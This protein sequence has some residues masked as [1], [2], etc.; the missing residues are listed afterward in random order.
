[1]ASSRKIAF[2][3]WIK[4]A[5]SMASWE[6]IKKECNRF[7]LVDDDNFVF[8]QYTGL[9]DKNGVEICEGDIVKLNP[10]DDD[11][12]D[13]VVW[14]ESKARF[15][16]KS[17]VDCPVK[18]TMTELARDSTMIKLADWVYGSHNPMLITGSIYENPELL[19]SMEGSE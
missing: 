8:M 1:M 19:E 15:E 7:S 2:R 4:S 18:N 12:A 3:A 5:K 9:K 14:W 17:F 16:L 11:W 10:D 13:S 6:L